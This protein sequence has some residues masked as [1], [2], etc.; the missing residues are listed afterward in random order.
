MRTCNSEQL[1]YAGERGCAGHS[2]RQRL[3]RQPLGRA[4]CPPQG[5]EEPLTQVISAPGN[6]PGHRA[7][8]APAARTGGGAGPSYRP[9]AV[10]PS[11]RPRYPRRGARAHDRCFGRRGPMRTWPSRRPKARLIGR[12]DS[13]AH[14]LRKGPF[15]CERGLFYCARGGNNSRRTKLWGARRRRRL[16][17]RTPTNSR[18]ARRDFDCGR[19]GR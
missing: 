17:V 4:L 3:G 11:W 15:R 14:F 12:R 8:P 10:R 9:G 2:A 7:C 5:G 16:H 1:R 19:P 18:A 13:R 6:C